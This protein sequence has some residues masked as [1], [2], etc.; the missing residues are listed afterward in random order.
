[1]KNK[2]MEQAARMMVQACRQ[3]HGSEESCRGC[4]FHENDELVD[5]SLSCFAGFP[6]TWVASL[7]ELREDE[8]L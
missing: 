6:R 5:A 3:Q 2:Q 4:E 7:P 8:K 1:M